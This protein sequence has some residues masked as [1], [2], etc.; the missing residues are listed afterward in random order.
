MMKLTV[1]IK[2]RPMP[3]Q[4]ALLHET[5]LRSNAAGNFL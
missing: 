2:L 1:T 4:V 5:L 3:A